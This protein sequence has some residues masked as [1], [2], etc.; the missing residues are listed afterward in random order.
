[1]NVDRM[2]DDI[3]DRRLPAWR[4]AEKSISTPKTTEQRLLKF[5]S[6]NKSVTK[7]DVANELGIH[8]EY[9][10]QLARK[11]NVL[12][13]RKPREGTK[14]SKIIAM[15]R[16]SQ[17]VQLSD[18]MSATGASESYILNVINEMAKQS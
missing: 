16:S 17:R 7:Y 8:P 5:V 15:L 6:E 18:I 2:L 14:K 11:N 12:L 13:K 3:F 10:S 1:M 4:H 9:V